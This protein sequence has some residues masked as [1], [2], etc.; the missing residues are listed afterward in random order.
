MVGAYDDA[1][2]RVT[3]RYDILSG[4]DRSIVDSSGVR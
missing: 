2:L 4:Y 1:N 3:I